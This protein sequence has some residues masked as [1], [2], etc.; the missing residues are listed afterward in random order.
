M[1][2]FQQ[3]PKMVYDESG[4]LVEVI[5]SARDFKSYLRDLAQEEDWE[6]LPDFLQ[7]AIDLLLIEEVRHEKE[8]ALDLDAVLGGEPPT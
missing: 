5:L 7:D 8:G 4:E 2:A 3:P 1:V 6:T